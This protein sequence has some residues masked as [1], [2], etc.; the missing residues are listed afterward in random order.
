MNYEMISDYKDNKMYRDSFNKLAESTFDI[1]F[2]EWFRSGFWNDK[3]VC[4]SYIDN[5][6]VISNVSINKMNLIYQGENYSALQIGTVMTHPNYRGQGLA[7]NL[8]NHVIAKYEDQ[9]DFLYLFANDTVL[10]FYPKFGFERIEESSFTVDACNLKKKASKLKKLNPDNKTDFQLISRIVSKRAPL[11]NILDVKESEDL[12][13]FYVLIALKN[14][15]YYL[16]ELDVIV[17][18]EQEGT[19]LYVLDILST[20][21][22]DV[23]EVLSY[24]STKKIET[25]HLLFTPEKSKYIDAAYI[26]ETE[27]MLFVRPNV[28]TIENYFLF[29]ATSHA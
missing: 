21:K 19:D 17:L 20:K 24:L 29:P 27:D 1:N 9:Y 4:Y 3:Y 7:K 26:I 22:L 8:L 6:E 15:L 5:N 2:E 12:L 28:L 11:S 10:D 23:V 13:M 14:E 18:M 16:E 25:I